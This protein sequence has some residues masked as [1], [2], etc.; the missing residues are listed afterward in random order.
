M[1]MDLPLTDAEIDDLGFDIHD[2]DETYHDLDD[3]WQRAI[4][5]RLADGDARC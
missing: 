3:A 1:R 4:A 2:N 5:R